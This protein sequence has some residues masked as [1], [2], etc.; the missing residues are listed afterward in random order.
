MPGGL[1]IPSLGTTW[2]AG[3]Q[4]PLGEGRI[5]PLPL[6]SLVGCGAMGGGAS[7]WLALGWGRAR[8]AGE[9]G[10]QWAFPGSQQRSGS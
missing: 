5:I 1:P 10:K 3:A 9:S 4:G 6:Y 7:G 2:E 8:G